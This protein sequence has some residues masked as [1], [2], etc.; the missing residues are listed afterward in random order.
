MDHTSGEE[1]IVY[2]RRQRVWRLEVDGISNTEHPKLDSE[3][4][5]GFID[6]KNEKTEVIQ[7]FSSFL[8]QMY[9]KLFN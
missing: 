6:S 1:V 5:V 8:Y 4:I 7:L 3:D 9:N 2:S